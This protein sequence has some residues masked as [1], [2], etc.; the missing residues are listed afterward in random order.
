MVALNFKANE[1]Y[2]DF[3]S[4]VNMK[5]GIDAQFLRTFHALG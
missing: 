2:F 5:K 3:K 4:I 1:P